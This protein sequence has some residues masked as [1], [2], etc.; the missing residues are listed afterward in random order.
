MNHRYQPY[1]SP[2]AVA[3]AANSAK[4]CRA[5]GCTKQR[6][7]LNAYCPQHQTVYRKYGHPKARPIK[8]SEY[9][10]YRKEVSAILEVNRS[11]PGF[12]AALDYVTRWCQ[13]SLVEGT[14]DKAAPELARLARV[15]VTPLDILVEACSFWCWLQDHP[16]ALPDTRAEDFAMS[17]AVMSLAPRPRRYTAEAN[18]KG[19][20]GYQLRPKFGALGAIGPRLREVLCRFFVNVAEAVST[21]DTRA[22]E[23]LEQLRAPL[24]SPTA[25]YLDKAAAAAPRGQPDQQQ[26]TPTTEPINK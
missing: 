25:V 13:A 18:L 14:T 24:A 1:L 15:A 5:S 17:R 26:H 4:S 23:A 11:H 8:A 3:K 7:G 6:K 16:R 12:V 20:T 22:Q 10:S 9:S 19:T 2:A 21:R